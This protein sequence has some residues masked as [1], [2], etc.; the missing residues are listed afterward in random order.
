MKKLA[1]VFLISITSYMY[2]KDEKV[3]KTNPREILQSQNIN[4]E[5]T[6]AMPQVIVKNE[7]KDFSQDAVSYTHLTLPTI[8]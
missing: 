8:E 4:E 5:N 7:P 2:F 1:F 3:I 6:K